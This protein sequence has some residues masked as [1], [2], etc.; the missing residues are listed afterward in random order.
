MSS[1][2]SPRPDCSMT[3][4]TSP[5]A[6]VSSALMGGMAPVSWVVL[7]RQKQMGLAV[8]SASPTARKGGVSSLLHQLVERDLLLDHLR[9]GQDEI[10]DIVLDHDRLDFAQAARVAVVP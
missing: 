5:S 10:R 3:I 4:G 6:W 7:Y 1:D 2:R 8:E 9:L